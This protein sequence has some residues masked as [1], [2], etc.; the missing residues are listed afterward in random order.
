GRTSEVFHAIGGGFFEKTCLSDSASSSA[1]S[2][3]VSMPAAREIAPVPDAPTADRDGHQ[4]APGAATVRSPTG[5]SGGRIALGPTPLVS[6]VVPILSASAGCAQSV[7]DQATAGCLQATSV[8]TTGMLFPGPH[9]G[10]VNN[11]QS[12][13]NSFVGGGKDN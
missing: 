7:R 6:G 13:T 1:L 8:P 4:H 9:L 3:P 2:G 12:G 11:V 10:G 5:N